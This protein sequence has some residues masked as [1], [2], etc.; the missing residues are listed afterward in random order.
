AVR[1][2]P[3]SKYENRDM[4]IRTTSTFSDANGNPSTSSSISWNG[5]SFYGYSTI[6][7]STWS[8]GSGDLASITYTGS[9]GTGCPVITTTTAAPG[10]YTYSVQ[11]D[12][13]SQNASIRY[14]DCDGN[15]VDDVIIP[16][17]SGTPD[18][19]AEQNSI[20]TNY[21][22][23]VITE[24]A[25]TCI[26][27]T[28]TLAPTT[29]VAPNNSWIAERFDGGVYAYVWLQQGYQINDLV[30][31]N[32]GSGQ[33]WTLGDQTT[34]NG[35]YNI[36]GTCPPP[37]TQPPAPTTTTAAPTTTTKPPATTTVAPT[38]TTT[39]QLPSNSYSI[40]SGQSTSDDSCNLFAFDVVWSISSDPEDGNRFYTDS[41]RTTPFNGGDQWFGIDLDGNGVTRS[42]RITSFGY[43][44]STTECTGGGGFP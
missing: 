37:T 5:Q 40:T 8:T 6:N 38:T 2:C 35:Q 39:T 17:D 28:T 32:D 7:S 10:C 9:V 33:C 42:T 3:E 12:S 41:A 44:Y 27:T 26:T 43:L 20:T 13:F 19:C 21:G 15:V 25:Q 1:G 34:A 4:Y 23:V 16:A 30:T 22:N 29:T 24:E 11:N 14:I 18:F 36:T 31:L